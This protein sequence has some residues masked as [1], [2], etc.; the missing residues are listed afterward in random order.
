VFISN[1]MLSWKHLLLE[2]KPTFEKSYCNSTNITKTETSINRYSKQ[3]AQE[4]CYKKSLN[5][6]TYAKRQEKITIRNELKIIRQ[7][8]DIN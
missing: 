1:H 7:V 8:Y 2:I 4:K 6:I 3:H 5:N